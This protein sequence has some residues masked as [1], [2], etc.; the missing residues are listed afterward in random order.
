MG[1]SHAG[2]DS[3]VLRGPRCSGVADFARSV[4]GSALPRHHGVWRDTVIME[5]RSARVGVD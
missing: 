4:I 3:G 2:V 1:G 5:R